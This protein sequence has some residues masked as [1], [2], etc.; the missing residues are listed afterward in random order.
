MPHL[1]VGDSV[2]IMKM[3]HCT[4]RKSR[5]MT[6]LRLVQRGVFRDAPAAARYAKNDL[7]IHCVKCN[8]PPWTS[9]TTSRKR[10]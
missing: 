3:E 9:E 7:R 4:K 1:L 5:S 2:L 6:T 8:M 10:A